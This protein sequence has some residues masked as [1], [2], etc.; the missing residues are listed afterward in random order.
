[1]FQSQRAADRITRCRGAA[2]SSL[3][4][5][6]LSARIDVQPVTVK[7]TKVHL[8]QVSFVLAAGQRNSTPCTGAR[9]C[10]SGAG[11]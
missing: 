7:F 10:T 4:T 1:M 5:R 11:G 2:R 9:G 6:K 3:L 8:A